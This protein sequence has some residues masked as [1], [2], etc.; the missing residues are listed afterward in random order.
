MRR[1]LLV[2]L[3][4]GTAFAGCLGGDEP[5][6]PTAVPVG[7]VPAGNLTAGSTYAFS[8]AGGDVTVA[9]DG[10]GHARIE[11]Y[12]PDDARLGG[13]ELVENATR[14][15]T[16]L[17]VAAGEPVLRVVDLNGT[18]RVTSDGGVVAGFWSLSAHL[19]RHI[20]A[21][22]PAGLYA[23]GGLFGQS[24]AD[25]R[26]NVTLLRAPLTLRLLA[27]HSYNGLTVQVHGAK[28]LVLAAE[29]AGGEAM[30]LP[31]FP[32]PPSL[33]EVAATFYPENLV[34]GRLNV[35][36]TAEG[37]EGA[38]ILE[39]WSYSRA[40]PLAP[41]VAALPLA[42]PAFL[43]GPLPDRPVMFQVHPQAKALL[44]QLEGNLS[45]GRDAPARNASAEVPAGSVMLFDAADRPLGVIAVPAGAV[46]SL[47]VTGGGAFV[48]VARS[49]TILLG[50]DRAP[51]D[52]ELHPLET[53]EDWQ[54]PQP[55]G[56]G[57]EYT[58]ATWEVPVQGVLYGVASDETY[59]TLP[60]VGLFGCPG[61]ESLALLQGNETIA[62]VLDDRDTASDAPRFLDGSPLLIRQDGFGTADCP[63]DQFRLTGYLRP[64]A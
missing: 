29:G 26:V 41:P 39:S 3:L 42:S 31:G 22:N 32:F 54:P 6:A 2:A 16:W 7:T 35:T 8:H 30:P 23:L 43:Y 40:L 57:D 15:A 62:L 50:A 13:L 55:A 37:L 17:E 56:T 24:P 20:L 11:L 19:E 4:L 1:R 59:G 48:A 36:L 61:G 49:G 12:G 5:A 46:V 18:L 51:A 38:V 45:D 44:L 27:S 14:S 53:W 28:G 25:A 10:A 34:D 21:E 33:E 63:F 60:T 47:P 9:L 64:T 52:F 58:Q